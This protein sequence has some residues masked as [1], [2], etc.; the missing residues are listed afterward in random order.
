MA[1]VGP[2]DTG[3]YDPF[4]MISESL[5]ALKEPEAPIAQQAKAAAETPKPQTK[6]ISV[7]EEVPVPEKKTRKVSR[8]SSLTSVKRFM[9]TRS[10]AVKLERAAVQ[11]GARL[12][13]SVDFSKLTRALWDTYLRHEED[14]LRNVPDD[15]YWERPANND[16]VALAELDE[17]LADLIND[18]FMVASRRP[19]NTR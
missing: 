15:E 9:T 6:D 7:S 13:I 5:T 3:Q 11:L 19:K 16:P 1:K 12:G 10:E 18:G 17:R 8:E 14:I 2:K 4:N